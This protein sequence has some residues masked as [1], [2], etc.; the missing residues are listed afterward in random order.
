[1]DNK[2]KEPYKNHQVVPVPT[3]VG[4][5]WSIWIGGEKITNN[6]AKHLYC[7]VHCTAAHEYWKKKGK[8]QEANQINWELLGTAFTEM[9]IPRRILTRFCS[10]AKKIGAN[11]SAVVEIPTFVS[12]I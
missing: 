12:S 1:M 11:L 7:L 9:S 5:P 4:E 8:I 6:V 10:N 3:L 2:A